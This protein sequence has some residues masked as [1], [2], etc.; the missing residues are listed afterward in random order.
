MEKFF[1][2][3]VNKIRGGMF[4]EK[5]DGLSVC[6]SGD[7]VLEKSVFIEKVY[8]G[9]KRRREEKENCRE[10]K[11][12]VQIQHDRADCLRY[13]KRVHKGND[14]HSYCPFFFFLLP[15]LNNVFFMLKKFVFI[16]LIFL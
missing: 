1:E 10:E 16:Q 2:N 5:F 7:F 6:M 11:E 15:V 9:S 12:T 14:F 13:V 3:Y 4:F 8:T